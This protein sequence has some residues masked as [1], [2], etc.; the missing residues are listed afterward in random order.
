MTQPVPDEWGPLADAWSAGPAAP[1]PAALRSHV[2]RQD[3]HLRLA[4]AFE[5]A[6]SVA[7][8]LLL[9]AALLTSRSWTERLVPLALAAFSARIWAFAIAN[10][11]GTWR[12]A[13]DTVEAFRRLSRLRHQRQLEAARFTWRISIVALPPLLA[14]AT[15]TWQRDGTVRSETTVALIGAAYVTACIVAGRARERQLRARDLSWLD[16]TDG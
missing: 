13:A 12:A 15:W 3:L 1:P 14:L 6:L 10:R 2:R 7:A 11:R 16:T 9:G 8:M 5:V 4:V